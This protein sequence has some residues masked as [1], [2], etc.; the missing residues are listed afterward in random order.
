MPNPL[1][2]SGSARARGIR[3][4]GDPAVTLPDGSIKALERRAAGL[5]AL[6]ALEPGV[7]RARAAALL[8]PDSENARQALRQQIARFRKVF[9]AELVSGEHALSL[10]DGVTA[11]LSAAA[12]GELL[13]A[14]SFDDCPDFAAWLAQQRQRRRGS[15]VAEIGQLLAEAEA[16]GDWEAAVKLAEQLLAADNDS[17][18]H[19]RTLMRLHYLRGDIAQAQAV[20]DRLARMLRT[21]FGARPSAETEQLARALRAAQ[22]VAVPAS[23]APPQPSVPV[24]VLRPPRMIGRQRELAAL[25]AAWQEGR[26]AL[27]RGEPGLGKTRLLSEFAAGRRVLTVQGRPG[28]AGVPYATLSRLLRTVFERSRIELPAPRRTELARLLPELAPS[29]PLPADGQRLLLQGAVEAVLAQARADG[30][31]T[32]GVIV[33]DLHFA[34]EASVEM[35]QAL[36]CGSGEGTLAGLRW[37]LAQRPGEGSAAAAALRNALDE[38]QAL[39]VIALA[40]LSI[41]E[42]AELIDSLGLPELDSAQLAPQLARHTGGNPLYALETLKQGLASDLLRQGRLPTPINVGAL[43]ERRLKQLS[44][45][46]LALA[47][48]AAIAGVDFNIALAEHVMGVRAVELADAWA[49]LEA[50]QVLREQAFAHDLVH[51]AVLRTVPSAIARHVHEQCAAWLQAH[52]GEPARVAVHWRNA[53]HPAEAAA[54]FEAAA[55][56]ALSASRRHEEAALHGEAAAMW[57]QAG[58]DDLRFEALAARVAALIAAAIDERSL[59]E[60]AALARHAANDAQR[61]RA[62]RVHMDMLSQSGQAQRAL[63]VGTPGLELARRIGAYEE[64]VRLAGPL[65]GCHCKLGRPDDGYALLL[66]LREWVDGHADDELRSLW[67]GYWAATLSHIGRLREAVAAYESSLAA[68]A[69]TGRREA[70]GAILLNLCVAVRT[71]GLLPRA[72]ETSRRALALMTEDEHETSNRTLA[73]LMHARDQAECGEYGDAIAAFEALLPRLEAMGSPFWP[74]AARTALATLWLH[75]GQHARASQAL[76]GAADD[77]TPAWM[78]AGRSLLRMEIADWAGRQPPRA[79]VEQALAL[80][81]GD[82]YRTPGVA[83]RGLRA[84]TPEEVLA[85]SDKLAAQVREQERFGLLLALAVF[86]ARAALDLGQMPRAVEA[87][88][89]ALTLYAEGY[90]PES[91]YA[92]EVHLTAWRALA[93]AGYAAEADAALCAGVDWVRTVALP[94][95]PLPFADSF[96]HRNPVNRAL[97]LQAQKS[98]GIASSAAQLRHARR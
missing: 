68:N 26:P 35:L 45:R 93:A 12:A 80:V 24:T 38:A 4:L 29:V 49:E 65:A 70:E 36:V 11:D 2:S 43:I 62:I 10:A 16:Q 92:P 94:N 74:C 64:Q 86:E 6:V 34:D 47:R 20:Y 22:P 1:T 58:R 67:Y 42:M 17:E 27:L 14:L 95:V 81:S 25:D 48:V 78:R 52:G 30:T 9:G 51:D 76:E 60:A 72:L 7:T 55:L 84:S 82:P 8:W 79:Q 61:V 3:L 66:P 88:R 44:D 96:L 83:V 98:A 57:A 56:R 54:A 87:A 32:D 97:L 53:A 5:L 21:R 46:A 37:A 77:S 41:D 13:G 18:A 28:D 59:A 33:D 50:A 91:M 63:E 39:A 40:P 89:R 90:R 19:H 85:Q 73:R 15:T 75:L 69:R 23:S 31:A 71:I